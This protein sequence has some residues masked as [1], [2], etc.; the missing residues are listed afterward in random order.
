M[1][2]KHIVPLKDLCNNYKQDIVDG[3]FG[4]NLTRSD[5]LSD[6]IPVLKI[7]NV[8]PFEVVLKRMDYVS[9]DK[10]DELKRHSYANGDIVMT[11][12]G[13]PLG[14]SAIIDGLDDGLIVADIVRIRA[15]K[16]DT[17]Y[18]CYH[19]NSPLTSKFINSLQK[20]TTRPR[21]RIDNVR[22]L[23]IYAPPLPE[24]QRIVSV[25]D[26]AFASLAQA[27]SNAEQNLVNARMLFDSVM[28]EMF[29]NGKN[30]VEKKLFEIGGTQTGTTP[31]T[32][33]KKNYGDYI[34]F[35]KPADIDIFGDGEIRYDNKGLSEVGL[36]NGRLMSEGSVL[37]VCIGASIGKVGYSYRDVSCNQQ[38]NALTVSKP[39]FPKFFYYTLRTQEFY[40]KVIKNSAQ[41][42]LPI[43]N[44]S[45]WENLTVRFPESVA[46]QRATVRRLEALSAE[47]GRLEEIY[48]SKINN[49]D[50]LKKSILAKAFR[51]EL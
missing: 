32:S 28:E 15:A 4:S 22:N 14:S 49:I 18:L 36:Q 31:K 39:N 47:T 33:E 51:G 38:I 3:P 40:N 11:K 20:G 29:G 42:T 26:E 19:L 30:W 6:G 7:Q 5:Y 12:L 34:P 44:K 41:A 45:K 13:D 48:Q 25:L 17:K 8:K 24:Q 27:K 16:V 2:A 23:P 1:K 35:I 10:Y 9:Q 21:V 43:I 50:E 37:M 46:E